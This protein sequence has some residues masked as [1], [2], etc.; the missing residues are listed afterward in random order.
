MYWLY[1]WLDLRVDF[2]YWPV[3]I[4]H[5][6]EFWIVTKIYF[7][8]RK[9]IDKQIKNNEA[10]FDIYRT[11]LSV[12]TQHLWH[13]NLFNNNHDFKRASTFNYFFV[14]MLPAN[15]HF[16]CKHRLILQNFIVLPID[17]YSVTCII[18]I[19]RIDNQ[20]WSSQ[21]EKPT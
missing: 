16:F 14:H 10:L 9:V 2:T 8:Y 12:I 13:N 5:D 21:N 3:N 4:V 6:L 20:L 7:G 15:S 1:I 18:Y 17:R 11:D 19:Y